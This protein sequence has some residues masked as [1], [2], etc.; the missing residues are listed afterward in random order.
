MGQPGAAAPPAPPERGEARAAARATKKQVVVVGGGF[1]GRAAQRAVA[2]AARGWFGPRVG[3]EVTLVDAKGYF[4]YTPALLRCLVEPAACK[5]ALLPHPKAVQ[6]TAVGF[7]TAVVAGERGEGGEE[8]EEG[9]KAGRAVATAVRLSDGRELPCDYCIWAQGAVYGA[10]APGGAA[11]GAGLSLRPRA[12]SLAERARELHEAHEG[13]L[14]AST[15]AVIG[16]GACGVELAAEI[17]GHFPGSKSILLLSRAEALLAH[18]PGDAQRYAEAWLKKRGV[19]VLLGCEVLGRTLT[20]DGR[21]RVATSVGGDLTVDL[22]F[23][24]S[25]NRFDVPAA[26]GGL[27]GVAAGRGGLGADA[28]LRMAGLANVFVCGDVLDAPFPKTAFTADVTGRLAGRNAVHALLGRPLLRYPED[29]CHG[30]D[31]PPALECVSLYKY[32]GVFQ[33]NSLVVPGLLA[34]GLKAFIERMQLAVAAGGCAATWS[35]RAIEDANVWLGRHLFLE[36][37]VSA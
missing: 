28:R 30:A 35:W 13:L 14:L 4:E 11:G 33:F 18:M 8:K 37:F 19:Q 5:R 12:A 21:H 29:V 31:R 6:G 2:E 36:G 25:G 7:A 9:A 22:V 24:C 15:V 1:A 17:A 20:A 32:D 23:D 34:G 10:L 27:P 3:L 16:G 26:V